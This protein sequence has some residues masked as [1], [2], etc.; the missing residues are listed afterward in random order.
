MEQFCLCPSLNQSR[1]SIVFQVQRLF[2]CPACGSVILLTIIT[3]VCVG[4]GGVGGGMGCLPV[5]CLSRIS[6]MGHIY[7]SIFY[8][9]VHFLLMH[10]GISGVES[11]QLSVDR[12]HN[13]R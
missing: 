2:V 5:F 1:G 13:L 4:V 6:D 12:F 11:S 7:H 9:K 3:F 10:C 8:L